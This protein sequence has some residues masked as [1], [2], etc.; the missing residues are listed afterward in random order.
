MAH[1]Y[2]FTSLA[3]TFSNSNNTYWSLVKGFA[4]IYRINKTDLNQ[5]ISLYEAESRKRIY[6]MSYSHLNNVKDS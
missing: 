5:A 1:P 4:H 3:R 6:G 2:I